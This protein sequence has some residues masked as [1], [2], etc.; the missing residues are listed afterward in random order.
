MQDLVQ[1]PLEVQKTL[2]TKTTLPK[3]KAN[4]QLCWI[5]KLIVSLTKLSKQ[6]VPLTTTPTIMV[7][8]PHDISS[9]A[10]TLVAIPKC[11]PLSHA[12]SKILTLGPNRAILLQQKLFNKTLFH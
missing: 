6:I 10:P 11:L 7:P 2:D 1:S 3:V 8:K 4:V 12:S 5:P 9:F